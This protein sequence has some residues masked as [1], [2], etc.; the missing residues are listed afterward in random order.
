M[1]FLSQPLKF[2]IVLFAPLKRK[3]RFV[4]KKTQAER[5]PSPRGRYCQMGYVVKLYRV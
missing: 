4:I 1:Y 2:V 5:Q 3:K